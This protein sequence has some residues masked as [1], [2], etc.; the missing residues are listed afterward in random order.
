M[1]V[2]PAQKAAKLQPSS[3]CPLSAL[4]PASQKKRKSNL[5]K[6]RE[7]NKKLL[8]KYEHTELTLDDEQS[9]EMGQIVNIIN[10]NGSDALH[11][12]FKEAKK[13]DGECE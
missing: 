7:H 8:R 2:T 13:R 11:N 4:S 3:N 10:Q 5:M 6:E 12:V 1:A 9:E